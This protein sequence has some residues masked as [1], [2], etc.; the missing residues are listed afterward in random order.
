MRPRPN[1]GSMTFGVNSRTEWTDGQMTMR[2]AECVRARLTRLFEGLPFDGQKVR[3][4]LEFPAVGR[5]NGS[6]PAKWTGR[7]SPE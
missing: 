3:R 7:V 5:S 1:D 2:L 6:R 4:E